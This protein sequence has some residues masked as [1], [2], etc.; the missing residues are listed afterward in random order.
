MNGPP[1]SLDY[2]L[3]LHCLRSCVSFKAS[4]PYTALFSCYRESPSKVLLT[5]QSLLLCFMILKQ[6]LRNADKFVET[7]H[8]NPNTSQLSI[9]QR[10]LAKLMKSG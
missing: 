8:V 10:G 7:P 6:I 4:T 1:L 5:L 3:S 2:F 9:L